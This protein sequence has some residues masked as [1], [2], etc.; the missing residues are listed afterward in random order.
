MGIEILGNKYLSNK[1]I[2]LKYDIYLSLFNLNRK[3]KYLVYK[4]LI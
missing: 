3:T 2:C 1:K 4:R